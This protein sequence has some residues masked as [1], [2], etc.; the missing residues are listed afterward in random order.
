[1]SNASQTGP[2]L[3]RYRELDGVRGIA[4]LAVFFHH[5]CFASLGKPPAGTSAAAAVERFI[6][7]IS[8]LGASGV[9]LFF[10]LSGFLITSLLI[11]DRSSPAYYKDFYW[12]RVLRILPLY[13]LCLGFVLWAFPGSGR[14]V[15]LALV[16]LPNLAYPLHIPAL[17][18]FWSLGIEEQF[19]VVWP[20]LI[21]RR[22]VESIARWAICIWFTSVLL[23]IIA[24]FLGH[25]DYYVTPFRVDGLAAGALLACR[26]VMRQKQGTCLA[27]DARYLVSAIVPGLVLG[28]FGV[29]PFPQRWPAFQA[30]SYETGVVLLA[31]GVI[32]LVI[33]YTGSKWLAALRSTPLLF[34]GLISYAFYMTHAYV[35]EFYDRFAGPLPEGR[36]SVFA[37]RFVIVLVVTTGVCLLTRYLLE[38]PALSLRRYVLARPTPK[39]ESAE[40]LIH[41]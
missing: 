11:K 18:P 40:P 1:M 24:A 5:V 23:R 30:T 35:M 33:G 22:S 31:F 39:P 10:V 20:T 36:P 3:Q 4:A 17:G 26:Q 14:Y 34:F 6:F 19:Y 13:L 12:K 7:Y 28:A 27:A 37:L 8:G 21:H 9:D 29:W 32:G 38:L 25:Y 2:S 41:S 15:L 16:F